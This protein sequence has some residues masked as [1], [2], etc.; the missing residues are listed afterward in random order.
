MPTVLYLG[1][2]GT[3]SYDAARTRFGDSQEL[4][5]CLSHHDIFARLCA[6]AARRNGTMALVPVENS[7]EGPVT[8]TLDLLATQPGLTIAE[9]FTLQVRHHLL[10]HTAVRRMKDIRRLYSHPQAL[11]QC[12]V[13][14]EKR[15]PHVEQIAE[16]STAAAAARAAGE[17]GSA[18]LASETAA[19]IYGLKI[20]KQDMQSSRGS[21][22][23]FM[24][25]SSR[26]SQTRVQCDDPRKIRSLMY[27]V[28]H[29]RPG[30]LLHA[31][32]PFDA[33][34]V[35]L[36]F[37]QSRPLPGRPWEYAFFIEAATDWTK[38]AHVAA[39]QFIMA[40]A[41]SGRQMGTYVAH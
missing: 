2:P 15:L 37:I 11:G 16:S 20:M 21:V 8:Q 32:A 18:A 24:V 35:N 7:T 36:T 41:D 3:H 4:A 26:R 25:L 22:T 6:G 33:A 31:L 14:I 39:W 13:N 9:S 34:G 28:L 23:R 1:P 38:P 19:A 5:P 17:P 12:R 29:N 40:L 10:A 27:V 30:A